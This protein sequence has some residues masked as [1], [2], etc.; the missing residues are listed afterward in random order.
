MLLILARLTD[1]PRYRS[2]DL[3]SG[4]IFGSHIALALELVRSRRTRQQSMLHSDRERIA[5]DLHDLVIQRLFAAGLGLQSV[6]RYTV[7]E[8][9]H[10][11]IASATGELDGIIRQLR[12]TI[13]ALGQ[14]PGRNEPLSSR[15]LRLIQDGA[16]S[17]VSPRLEFAGTVDATVPERLS[18][19]L[20]AVLEEGMSNAI[21]HSG[22]TH[23]TASVTTS[24]RLVTLMIVDDGGGFSSP[25][26]RRGL[27][28]MENRCEALNGEF[29]IDSPL[30]TGTRL[31]WTA[32]LGPV[33]AA[34]AAVE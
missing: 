5:R 27:S 1:A 6:H 19:H 30:G 34:V 13:S 12:A 25:A 21:K 26:K 17:E 24:S 22:A 10:A 7:D 9:A 4:T 18:N 15:M 31:T 23:I 14:H 32:P 16:T 20:L 8:E 11:R 3:E 2:V 28:N 29:T 33:V